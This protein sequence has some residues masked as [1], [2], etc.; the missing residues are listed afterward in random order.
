MKLDRS[1]E[2]R[3]VSGPSRGRGPHIS[4]ERRAEPRLPAVDGRTWLGWWASESEFATVGSLVLNLSRG[5]ARILTPTP[6]APGDE[7]WLKAAKAAPSDC[8]VGEVLEVSPT[9]DGGHFV[10][11]RFDEHCP[12]DLFEAIT[13]G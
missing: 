2:R 11:V 4:L 13:R 10:R 5:G 12:D 6:P 7:V 8:A 9:G 3:M 1:T